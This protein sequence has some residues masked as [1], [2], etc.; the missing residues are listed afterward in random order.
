MTVQPKIIPNCGS[1]SN[2]P[3]FSVMMSLAASITHTL[4]WRDCL[5]GSKVQVQAAQALWLEITD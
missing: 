4:A 3:L 2:T 5:A 1:R